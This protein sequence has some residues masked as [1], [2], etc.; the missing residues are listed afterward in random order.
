MNEKN[1]FKGVIQFVRGCT[2][3]TCWACFW[4]QVCLSLELKLL[5]TIAIFFHRE[6]VSQ[7]TSSFCY[8][9]LHLLLHHE[10]FTL[11]KCKLR[12]GLQWRGL[13]DEVLCIGSLLEN[14]TFE[15]VRETG[16]A[17]GY[18]KPQRGPANAEGA[19][20]LGWPFKVF[21]SWGKGTGP[22]YPSA[23]RGLPGE[24]GGSLGLRAILGER[25]NS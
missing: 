2:S 22:F 8:D 9:F 7:H 4:T 21:P 1:R 10:L 23:T 20:Q 18:M 12:S 16:L 6:L 13:W 3:S 24:Q 25:L 17:E 11:L 15:G 14:S 19:L 5:I